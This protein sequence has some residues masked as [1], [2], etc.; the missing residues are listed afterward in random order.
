[1]LQHDVLPMSLFKE[2]ATQMENGPL[3]VHTGRLWRFARA[4]PAPPVGD[5]E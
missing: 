1:M 3:L 4:L 2:P 5:E